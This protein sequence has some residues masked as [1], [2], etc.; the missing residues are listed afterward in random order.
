MAD[1]MSTTQKQTQIQFSQEQQIE[2]QEGQ[3][4]AGP[5]QMQEKL[6]AEHERSVDARLE[7]IKSGFAT[8]HFQDNSYR[9]LD[10]TAPEEPSFSVTQDAFAIKKKLATKRVEQVLSLL[11]NYYSAKSER[12]SDSAEALNDLIRGC[13]IFGAL[14]VGAVSRN[15]NSKGQKEVSHIYNEAIREKSHLQE[16]NGASA[17]KSEVLLSH[18]K[19]LAYNRTAF[20]KAQQ[21]GSEL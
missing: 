11:H 14:N 6:S 18:E 16:E 10:R 4:Q 7:Q 1:L 12:P 13:R 9:K 15:R 17:S 20:Q 19:N 2:R 8:V 21:L 3:Y 5:M